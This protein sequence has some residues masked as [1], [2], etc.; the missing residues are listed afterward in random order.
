[1]KRFYLLLFISFCFFG[2]IGNSGYA[3]NS[4][5]DNLKALSAIKAAPPID[6]SVH[7]LIGSYYREQTFNI[8]VKSRID[9]LIQF[10]WGSGSPFPGEIGNNDFSVRWVGYIK[11]PVTGTYTFYTQSDDGARVIIGGLIFIDYWGTCCREFSGKIYLEAGKLYPFV[12]EFREGGGGANAKY[13]DWEAPGLPRELVPHSA[14]YATAPP[15]QLPDPDVSKDTVHGLIGRYY[16]DPNSNPKWFDTLVATRIDAQVNFDWGSNSPM[17]GRMKKDYFSVRWQGYIQPPVTG[18]YTFITNTDDGSRLWVD[19]KLIIDHWERCCQDET[20]TIDLIAGKLYRIRLDMHE[21]GGGAAAKYIKWQAPGLPLENIPNEAYYTVRLQTVFQPE[22]TPVSAIYVDSVVVTMNTLTFGSAIHYTLDGSEPNE[23]SPV[24]SDT[25]PLVIKNDTRVRARAFHAGM[26]PSQPTSANYRIIPPLVSTPTFTPSQGI[27]GEP[28]NV[29]ITTVDTA[30]TI[31][32]TLDGSN[33]DTNSTVFTT[34]IPI[35]S[36]TRVKA[37]ATRS[38]RTPSIVASA[39]FTMLPPAADTPVFSIPGGHYDVAQTVEITSA[40][41][42]AVIHYALNDDVLNDASPIYS[43]PI[44]IN[45][46]TTLKA[47]ASKDTLRTSKVTMATYQIGTEQARVDTPAF[48]LSAGK[49]MSVQQVAI[50]TNTKDA[51][52]HYTIDGS[53][54]TDT[55]DIYITPILIDDSITLKAIAVKQGMLPSAISSSTYIVEAVKQGD[56]IV[57]DQLPTPQLTIFPNPASNQVRISWDNMIYDLDGTYLTITDSKGVIM[58]RVVIKGGYTYFDLQ[59]STF[60]NG[61]YFVRIKS[62]QSVLYGKLIVG[63]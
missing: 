45:E 7:G 9:S 61:V 56:G 34:P 19:D 29:E 39:T 20:G 1:M 21:I 4:N 60:A 26:L 58:K 32:Y 22:I 46:T 10:D 27:Y 53:E 23:N 14:F 12:Y 42:G 55:S 41:P 59:T 25:V 6:T 15:V 30:T 16:H 44:T 36:T 31:Y 63:R 3:N 18:T 40:T 37:F 8:F 35:D 28:V 5:P 51:I 47:Y 57:N 33:P 62:G 50:F 54:P 17:P 24:Y 13:L 52:I 48:S 2:L 43:G 49:Y 38:D 11:A